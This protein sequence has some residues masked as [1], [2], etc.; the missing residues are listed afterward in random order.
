MADQTFSSEVISKELKKA[1]VKIK[2]DSFE[3]ILSDFLTTNSSNKK[4][5]DSSK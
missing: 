3:N 4:A 5:T 2:D 1:N